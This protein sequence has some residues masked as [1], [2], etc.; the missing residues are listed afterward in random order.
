MAAEEEDE[1]DVTAAPLVPSDEPSVPEPLAVTSSS[2]LQSIGRIGNSNDG[3]NSGE[4]E[5]K[6]GGGYYSVGQECDVKDSVGKWSE[7]IVEEVDAR[8]H[9]IYISYVYW[10]SNWDEWIDCDNSGRIAQRGAHT[11]LSGGVLKVGQRIDILD[12][13]NKWCEAEVIDE[14]EDAVFVHFRCVYPDLFFFVSLRFGSPEMYVH[15]CV[16]GDI[17]WL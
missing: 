15:S 8:R 12:T 3:N 4:D 10:S 14:R 1:V 9:R 7:A 11:Y 2:H 17:F 13:V 16:C 6:A 5:R